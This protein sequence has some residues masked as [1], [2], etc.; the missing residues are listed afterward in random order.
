M[1]TES[2]DKLREI[3]HRYLAGERTYSADHVIAKLEHYL[4]I[5]RVRA[6][7][8]FKKMVEADVLDRIPGD[9]PLYF[10]ADSTPF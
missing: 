8:G 7:T 6:E 9:A 2:R 10:L 5:P 1:T 3:A 4:R